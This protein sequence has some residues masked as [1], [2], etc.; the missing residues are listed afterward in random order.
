MAWIKCSECGKRISDKNEKCPRCGSSQVDEALKKNKKTI[1]LDIV[2]ILL[3]LLLSSIL[4]FYTDELLYSE[5]ISDLSIVFSLCLALFFN[6]FFLV[7]RIYFLK[8]TCF[9]KI[10]LVILSFC[11]LSVGLIYSIKSVYALY[12]SNSLELIE[13]TEKYGYKS[14]RKIKNEIERVFEYD[15]DDVYSRDVLIENFYQDDDIYLLYLN[16][17]YDN[18]RLKFFIEMKDF[19]FNNVYYEFDDEKMYLMQDGKKTDNFEYYYAMY[20]LDNM[21]GEDVTGLASVTKDI[22]SELSKEFDSA[23]YIYTYDEFRFDSKKN[24][25]VLEAE[26]LNMDYFGNMDAHTFEVEFLKETDEKKRKI[27][28]YGDSSFDYVNFN[29]NM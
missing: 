22:E 29:V 28:Y 11:S 9:L 14:S 18:Y 6:L 2:N 7:K 13:L 1:F 24:K 21:I 23:S 25:F 10:I 5:V 8:K 3:L 4:I 27:W 20:I 17:A 15:Y 12:Y 16:D 19:K 26:V